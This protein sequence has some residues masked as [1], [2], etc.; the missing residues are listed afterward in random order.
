MEN[1]DAEIIERKSVLLR[2]YRVFGLEQCEG[3]AAPEPVRVVNPIE[4]AS[5]SSAGP[6]LPAIEQGGRAWYR[7]STDTV[8]MPARNAHRGYHDCFDTPP[9]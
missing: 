2:Y 9:S 1:A 5:A 7:P 6:N 8:R 3:I 4:N